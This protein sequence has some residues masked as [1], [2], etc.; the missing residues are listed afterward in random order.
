MSFRYI[1][2]RVHHNNAMVYLIEEAICLYN[3][4][5]LQLYH[6]KHLLL[7]RTKLRHLKN[8]KIIVLLT[9]F[10][11]NIPVPLEDA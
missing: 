10:Y 8:L 11:I 5:R 3:N 2:G 7:L 1:I 4:S 9:Q 6:Q